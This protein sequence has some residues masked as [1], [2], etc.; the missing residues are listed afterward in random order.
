[1]HRLSRF[2]LQ[3]TSAGGGG[4]GTCAAFEAGGPT[5]LELE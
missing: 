3:Q 1:V 5:K 4:L 2:V